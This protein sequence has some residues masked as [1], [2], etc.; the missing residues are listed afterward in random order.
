MKTL[1]DCIPCVIRQS[2]HAARSVTADETIH[3][4]IVREALRSVS[5]T[6]LN[7]SPPAL[8]QRIHARIRELTQT[9]DPYREA[10][11]RQNQAALAMYPDLSRRVKEASNPLEVAVRLAIAGNAMDL[12]IMREQR[13]SD[14]RESV[15]AALEEPWDGQ[16]KQFAHAIEH[17]SHI[18]YL[19]DNAGEI[20]LDRLLIEQLS[21]ENV[22]LAVRGAPVINDATMADAEIA[23]ITDVVAVIDNGSDAPG[24]ILADC[25]DRFLRH[26]SEADLII[27]KGQGNYET[28]RESARPVYFL[29]RAKCDA[30][31]RD[32][33]CS[34]G[35]MILRPSRASAPAVSETTR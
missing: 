27:S 21:P 34:V 16:I 18:L 29:L 26:F 12:A 30:V 8:G 11:T 3:E 14:I 28:L 25:N 20:V 17:A 24:T 35:Q 7:E 4:R 13:E 5:E 6:D 1:L 32:L 31:A 19:A 2:L 10:K 33:G 23:G 9:A 15:T 22:V